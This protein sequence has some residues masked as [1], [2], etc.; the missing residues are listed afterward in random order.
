[1]K[2]TARASLAISLFCASFASFAASTGKPIDIVPI[3]VLRAEQE[4][5]MA[6]VFAKLK[7]MIQEA[8]AAQAK[9]K[10][11]IE[12]EFMATGV[13]QIL[14]AENLATPEGIKRSRATLASAGEI[15]N[16]RQQMARDHLKQ[17]EER[18][19][20][21]VPSTEA[22]GPFWEGMART[23]GQQQQLLQQSAANQ[24]AVLA[25]I[26]G[27]VDF[28]AEHQAGVE[29]SPNR[30]LVFPDQATLDGFNQ[31]MAQFQKLAQEEHQIKEEHESRRDDAQKKL[32]ELNLLET[33]N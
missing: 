28:M 31:R 12:R 20:A 6:A 4:R 16:R 29:I 32:G 21:I 33:K 25:A 9:M 1:M 30:E 2:N 17:A 8:L 22:W 13:G 10:E 15:E 23:S 24:V 27:V 11:D 5:E 7:P 26:A 19:R 18:I 14:S 3:Q